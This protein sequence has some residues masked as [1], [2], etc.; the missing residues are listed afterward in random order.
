MVLLGFRTFRYQLHSI[1]IASFA[2]FWFFAFGHDMLK[3]RD[4]KPPRKT[5][6]ALH[7]QT[8]APDPWAL[9]LKP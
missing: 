6:E 7:P 2:S 1:L 3:H 9:N 8:Q 5:S 4:P